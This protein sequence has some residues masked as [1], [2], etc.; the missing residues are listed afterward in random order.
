MDPGPRFG[1][2]I[3]LWVDRWSD[4]AA[5][6][7]DRARGLGLDALEI[8]VG[9]DVPV[10]PAALR[11]RAAAAGIDVTFGPGGAW[12]VECDISADDPA[13]RKRGLDWH[14]RW[15]RAAG[16]CGA[17][18]YTGALYGHPGT[19][20]RRRP[21]TD[22]LPRTAANLRRMA[23]EAERA[24]IVLALE[25]MSR[26][27]THL[28]NT[29]EQIMRLIGMADHP[30]LRALLDTYHMVTE[31]RDYAAAARTLA[32]R[33]WG[34]HACES[35]R[36]VPGGGLVPWDAL[37][38]ALVGSGF[39]EYL[40]LEVYNTGLGDFG[41]QRGIF[42]DICPDGDDFVRRGMAFLKDAISAARRA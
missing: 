1:A 34:I 22:E 14:T 9:D 19:V 26:F 27:R 25:P 41:F 13:H 8:A 18:A 40:F 12:P 32:P 4:A 36:G 20:H 33:L 21:P 28:V 10:D 29:P 39:P 5:R 16:E 7:F 42:R 6:L 23:E 37:F 35:D 17:V 15:I 38:K 3:Y 2:H 31:V 30:R 11:R 24:G